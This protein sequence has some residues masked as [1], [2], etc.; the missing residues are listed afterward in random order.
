MRLSFRWLRA[1]VEIDATAHEVADRLTMAG[2]EVEGVYDRFPHLKKVVPAKILRVM[3]HPSADRLKLCRCTDGNRE[4]GI[5]CGAPNVREGITVP[6][7]LPGAKLPSGIRIGEALIRGEKSEGMLASQ[8][9]LGLGEDASGLWILPDD[10]PLGIPLDRALDIEDWILE[11]SV[12]PNRGDCLSVIGLAREVAALYGKKV[13]YPEISLSEEGPPVEQVARVDIEDPEKCPRYTARVLFD[14]TIGPSPRWMVDRLE[15][16]GIRSIN[17]VVDVTNYVM[18][19]MGQPLH[20]FDYDRLAE[21]RIV[22]R[23]ARSGEV[24]RTL[25][26]QD[27]ILFDDTLMICD[28]RGPVAIGGIMGGENSEITSET[29]HVLIESAWFNPLSIRRTSKKLRLS[30]ESSYRFERSVDPE[31]VVKALD[32]AAQLMMETAGGRLARGIIDVYPRP[33]RRP[34]L[35]LRVDR[36]NRYLGTS[37]SVEEMESALKRLEMEVDKIDGNNLRVIPPSYRQDVTREVDLTE[38]IARI[39]GYDRVPTKHPGTTV[40]PREEDTHLRLREELKDLCRGMGLTEILTF[41]FISQ[42]SLGKLRLPERDVRLRPIKLMNP[43]SEEQAV[44]RT[45]LIPNMLETIRFNLDRQNESLRLFELSKVFIPKGTDQLPQEDFQLVVALTGLR[46]DDPL[47]DPNPAD[48]ADIKG[49]CENIMDFFRI[50]EVKYSKDELPP[51]MDPVKAASLFVKGEYVG[52]VGK[53][54]PLVVEAF[55]IAV[56]VW[57]LELDFEKLFRM[58]GLSLS[59]RPLPKYPFVPRD[60]AVVADEDFPVQ[61]ILDY[62]NN[63]EE[64]LLEKVFIFDIFRSKQLGEGKKSVAY[65]IIYRHPERSLTDEEVNEL[66]GRIVQKILETFD[67]RLR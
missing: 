10:I 2:L 50:P 7:A 38:E 5:V 51:Y 34:V 15:S 12:T 6:L 48:Y 14:V 56:P 20:A 13:R 67:L 9:E 47:Y 30:S 39:I 19:E 21:H 61:E 1:Y 11:I 18:L 43:L 53:I 44:M 46:T 23:C 65:R 64:P 28:G 62:L 3:N 26:G 17:N 31:G 52:T 24:F 41:S 60:L 66:H 42:S 33:H 49:I 54:H 16:A 57:L 37:F 59:F 22:V 27:R 55:D 45:S 4:Y 32:R 58:R 36:T 35:H 63:L 40:M 29:R 25:D 8:K